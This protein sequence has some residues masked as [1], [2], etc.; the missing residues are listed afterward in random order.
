MLSRHAHKSL[1]RRKQKPCIFFA[2]QNTVSS[3]YI[4]VTHRPTFILFVARYQSRL[5]PQKHV[6]FICK[7]Y[8]DLSEQ[9]KYS[10]LSS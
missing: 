7:R 2:S 3:L 6:G 4:V 5:S 10:L 8:T 1:Y 9:N